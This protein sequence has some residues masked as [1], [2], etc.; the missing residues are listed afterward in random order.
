[1]KNNIHT[2][3]YLQNCFN[4]YGEEE[5]YFNILEFCDPLIRISREAYYIQKLKTTMNLQD[6][7]TKVL[8]KESKEKISKS[9]KESYANNIH[10]K[11]DKKPVEMYDLAGYFIEDFIN[12]EEA[13][14]K[15]GVSIHHI[16]VTASKYYEGRVCGINRFRYKDSKIQPQK[17]NYIRPQ[18][19]TK[20]FDLYIIEPTG[21]EIP[22]KSGIKNINQMLV[23]QL[24]KGKREIVLS[25]R[26]TRSE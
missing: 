1:M 2:N 24:V 20:Y 21:E 3:G 19:I 5:I 12:C 11:P 15:M 23:D 4:K 14:K 16:Q 22:I 9:L 8:S 10:K 17:F 26:P 7:V 18:V 25:A 13:A 6:P